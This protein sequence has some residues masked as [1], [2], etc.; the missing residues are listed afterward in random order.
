MVSG[1]MLFYNEGFKTKIVFE[2][3]NEKLWL[4]Q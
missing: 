3:N 2:F 4:I 1:L